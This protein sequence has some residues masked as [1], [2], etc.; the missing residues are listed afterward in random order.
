MEIELDILIEVLEASLKKNGDKPLN[1]S[2][3]INILKLVKNIQ[4]RESEKDMIHDDIF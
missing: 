4:E 3:F 1:I 2:H